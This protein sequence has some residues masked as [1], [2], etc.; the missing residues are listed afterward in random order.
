MVSTIIFFA[1]GIVCFGL[2]LYCLTK[3]STQ[4]WTGSLLGLTLMCGIFTIVFFGIATFIAAPKELGWH[5]EIGADG[6]TLSYP[7][8][9]P[10][11][12]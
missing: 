8:P 3:A 1:I 4:K 10:K 6:S 2:T 5:T 7:A 11:N 12:R 9:T